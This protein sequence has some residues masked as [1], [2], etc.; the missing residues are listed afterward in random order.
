MKCNIF[1]LVFTASGV[2]PI[3]TCLLQISQRASH[4]TITPS[5]IVHSY[6]QYCMQSWKHASV[7]LQCDRNRRVVVY[8]GG[9]GSVHKIPVG[10]RELRMGLALSLVGVTLACGSLLPYC[11]HVFCIWLKKCNKGWDFQSL[12]EASAQVL[13]GFHTLWVPD[14]VS[15][16]QNPS[17][18]LFLYLKTMFS[19]QRFQM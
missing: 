4:L 6:K 2:H 16:F 14:T 15:T 1:F 12:W 19:V 5:L 11:F 9:P 3:C 13:L 18:Q 17:P 7:W 10:F 8:L